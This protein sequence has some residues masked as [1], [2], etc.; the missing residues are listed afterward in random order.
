MKGHFIKFQQSKH[1]KLIEIDFLASKAVRLRLEGKFSVEWLL[2]FL[3]AKQVRKVPSSL[4]G[5]DL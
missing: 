2:H 5:V 4:P 1:I 3:C